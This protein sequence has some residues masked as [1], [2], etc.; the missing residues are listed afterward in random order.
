MIGEAFFGCAFTQPDVLLFLVI[1]Q[2]RYYCCFVDDIRGQA[3][4]VHWAIV[5][6]HTIAS[7]LNIGWL[8]CYANIFLLCLLMTAFMFAIQL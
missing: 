5:L 4:V 6:I 8:G 7:S 1:W 3:V 2:V